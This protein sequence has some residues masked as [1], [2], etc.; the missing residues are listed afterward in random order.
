M[1]DNFLERHRE[2]YEQRK[3]A[4][5]RRKKHLPKI[6]KPAIL[7]PDDEALYKSLYFK[8]GCVMVYDTPFFRLFIEFSSSDYAE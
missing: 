5:L 7:R 6:K 2:D 4:W 1:A 8:R 3:A